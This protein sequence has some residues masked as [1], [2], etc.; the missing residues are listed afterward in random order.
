MFSTGCSSPRLRRFWLSRVHSFCR[1]VPGFLRAVPSSHRASGG[2]ARVAG[3]L[4]IDGDITCIEWLDE[5][6]AELRKVLQTAAVEVPDK[7]ARML[8]RAAL[9][10]RALGGDAGPP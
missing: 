5:Y 7:V 10:I 3:I 2:R 9:T 4:A 8:K 6:I 1:G